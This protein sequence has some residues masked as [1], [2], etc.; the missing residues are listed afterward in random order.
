MKFYIASRVKNRELVRNIHD[1]LSELGHE[2]LSDWIDERNIIPYENHPEESKVRSIQCVNYCTNADVFVLISDEGGAGMY[3]EL[4]V[5]LA[6]SKLNDKPKIYV[7][8]NYL[9]RSIFFFHPAI[10]RF[11]NFEEVLEDLAK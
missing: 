6:S 10:K 4:G 5:V 9:N 3:T 7:I 11:K 8:G 1:T 2:T